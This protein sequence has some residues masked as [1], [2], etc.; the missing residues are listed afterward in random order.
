MLG[1]QPSSGQ[2]MP[3]GRPRE[4]SQ[5]VLLNDVACPPAR[6]AHTHTHTEGR[7]AQIQNK[8]L[9]FRACTCDFAG[10]MHIETMETNMPELIG[11]KHA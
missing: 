5:V 3:L 4:N 2:D 6:S 1:S 7:N 9:D 10:D 8:M 11:I